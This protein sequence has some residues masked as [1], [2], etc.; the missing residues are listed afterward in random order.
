MRV[1]TR[2]DGGVDGEPLEKRGGAGI[3]ADRLVEQRA[4]TLRS[5][6]AREID[7]V[8]EESDCGGRGTQR[9][10]R[11]F[12]RPDETRTRK[13]G[14]ER[15]RHGK[16]R[17]GRRT[18]EVRRVEEEAGGKEAPMGKLGGARNRTRNVGRKE[19]TR[20]MGEVVRG[21]GEGEWFTA[22]VAGTGE[23]RNRTPARMREERKQGT[24]NTGRTVGA[25]A[26]RRRGGG[27]LKEKSVRDGNSRRGSAVRDRRW[28]RRR[29]WGQAN[30]EKARRQLATLAFS[31]SRRRVCGGKAGQG[32]GMNKPSESNVKGKEGVWIGREDRRRTERV[33]AESR[34]RRKGTGTQSEPKVVGG[35]ENGWAQKADWGGLAWAALCAQ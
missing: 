14:E 34:G 13:A 12:R 32:P 29:G 20:V 24:R 30:G 23:A 2:R 26:R 10:A 6:S 1:R 31:V 28:G 19:G 7:G 18:R 21:A 16:Q 25:R 8:G 3:F 4:R 11:F 27:R 9:G 22:H 15:R 33:G 17:R 5:G 35:M